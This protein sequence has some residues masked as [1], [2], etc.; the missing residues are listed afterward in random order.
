MTYLLTK[1][2]D[3]HVNH[4][5]AIIMSISIKWKPS[6]NGAAFIPMKCIDGRLNVFNVRVAPAHFHPVLP[7]HVDDP[8]YKGQF[9]FR[10]ARENTFN[11]RN[12]QWN[13]PAIQ[14]AQQG[15]E[16]QDFPVPGVFL[17]CELYLCGRTLD[18]AWQL[19]IESD[20]YKPLSWDGYLN[21]MRKYYPLMSPYYQSFNV[22]KIFYC[23]RL[24]RQFKILNAPKCGPRKSKPN[25]ELLKRDPFR[26]IF[27]IRGLD[28]SLLGGA[29]FFDNF[30][31]GDIIAEF[32][33]LGSYK[34]CR[35]F[36]WCFL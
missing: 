4:Q 33:L 7:E 1:L 15:N 34:L 6:N 11:R 8:H 32:R 21:L 13:D 19:L 23:L 16:T 24:A 29:E 22:A 27:K 30:L 28:L 35:C 26:I 14:G 9:T 2:V 25:Y 3:I 20:N 5:F 17:F 36:L 12:L 10:D 18:P 31:K